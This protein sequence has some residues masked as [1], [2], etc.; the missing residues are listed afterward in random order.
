MPLPLALTRCALAGGLI[1]SASLAVAQN[2]PLPPARPGSSSSAATAPIPTPAAPVQPAKAEGPLD[3][4]AVIERANTYLNSLTSL[5]GDFTQVGGDGK[6]YRGRLYVQKPGKLRFE[7]D[8]PAV[9]EVVSDGTSVIVRDRKAAT[10]DLYAIGQTPLKF[11]LKDRLDLTRDTTVLRTT[12]EGANATVT[13]ED[14]NTLGGVS[15]ITLTFDARTFT[16]KNWRIRDPQ[17]NDT[18]VAL[19]NIEPNARTDPGK[20]VINYERVLR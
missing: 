17:G 7:Y 19:S 1:F 20:F 5:S 4:G 2:P 18:F 14:K 11:L 13:L 3:Q 9:I 16:L 12:A 6:Q 15:R 10:Q 8:P